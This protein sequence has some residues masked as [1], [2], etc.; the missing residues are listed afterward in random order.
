[1]V[2]KE[3]HLTGFQNLMEAATYSHAA[4]MTKMVQCFKKEKYSRK[5]KKGRR[6]ELVGGLKMKKIFVFWL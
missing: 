4:E 1:V 5:R 6:M 2:R 3:K